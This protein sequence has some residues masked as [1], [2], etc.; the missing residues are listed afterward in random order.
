M[1][2]KDSV[3][4]QHMYYYGLSTFMINKY[5]FSTR[6]MSYYGFHRVV[7]NKHTS[8]E[9]KKLK[10]CLSLPMRV[11]NKLTPEPKSKMAE[12]MPKHTGREQKS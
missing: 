8:R 4:R 7:S 1:I 5:G 11:A 2:N 12:I 10:I 6:H 9:Q 3:H